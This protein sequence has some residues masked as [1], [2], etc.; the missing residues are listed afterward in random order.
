[1][2]VFGLGKP[3]CGDT[4]KSGEDGT[5]Q[6]GERSPG[7]I[8]IQSSHS[9]PKAM[10]IASLKAIGYFGMPKVRASSDRTYFVGLRKAGMP[11][12]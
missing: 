6:H 8:S 3:G 2:G 5:K 10:S 9:R 12:E 4:D 11:K 7:M 1:M